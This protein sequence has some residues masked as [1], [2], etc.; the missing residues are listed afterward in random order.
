MRAA[1]ALVVLLFVGAAACV[2]TGVAMLAD[3]AWALIASGF[4]LFGAGV[5]LRHGLTRNG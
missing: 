5:A 1:I 3:T 2:V 4:I